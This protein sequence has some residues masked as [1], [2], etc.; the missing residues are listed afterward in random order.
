MMSGSCMHGKGE[1][2]MLVR[3]KGENV[4]LI[5]VKGAIKRVGNGAAEV[6]G[7]RGEIM[8]CKCVESMWCPVIAPE[9]QLSIIPSPVGI[10]NTSI[11]LYTIW[12]GGGPGTEH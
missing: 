6:A 4:S 5:H 7:N 11:L 12:E 8:D 2:V 3:G 10:K 9:S 1:N